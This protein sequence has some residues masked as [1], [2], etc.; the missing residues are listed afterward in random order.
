M[1]K[2]R[3]QENRKKSIKIVLLSQILSNKQ[4]EFLMSSLEILLFAQNFILNVVDRKCTEFN[5]DL[6][7]FCYFFLVLSIGDI[8][9]L[10]P[11]LC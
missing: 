11:K 8:N 6:T 4:V 3:K 5:K 7:F 1:L 10:K 2:T 9:F